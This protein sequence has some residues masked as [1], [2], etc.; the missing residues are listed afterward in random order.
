MW[1]HYADQYQGTVWFA[2]DHQFF[3]DQMMLEP[4]E[5]DLLRKDL[6]AALARI[7]GDR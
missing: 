1:S 4:F 7:R 3:A 5:I 2:A 6:K